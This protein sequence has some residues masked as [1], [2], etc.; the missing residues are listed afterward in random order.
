M[1]SLTLAGDET[2]DNLARGERPQVFGLICAIGYPPTAEL[3]RAY[4]IFRRNCTEAWNAR[5]ILSADDYFLYQGSSLHCTVA[6]FHSFKESASLDVQ[7][8]VSFWD[9][10]LTRAKSF[11]EWPTRGCVQVAGAHLDAA[12]AGY[13][14]LNDVDSCV[15]RL[16]ECI[17]KACDSF[18]GVIDGFASDKAELVSRIRIPGIVHATVLRWRRDIKF[19]RAADFYKLAEDF[20][21]SF[22]TECSVRIPV[23]HAALVREESPYMTQSNIVAKYDLRDVYL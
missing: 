14:L 9:E 19:T 22:T 7:T 10:L 12:G 20:R 1:G 23:N 2:V 11:P 13:L 15:K 18:V 4:D 16:R 8:L 17:A 21:S 5:P 6:T 3:Q